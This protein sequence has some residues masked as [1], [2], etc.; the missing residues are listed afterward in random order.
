M[1][2][3]KFKKQNMH[4]NRRGAELKSQSRV[5]HINIPGTIEQIID[6]KSQNVF[7]LRKYIVYVMSWPGH[8]ALLYILARTTMKTANMW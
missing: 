8:L 5:M 2:N 3:M 6:Q 4:F 1:I 7:S